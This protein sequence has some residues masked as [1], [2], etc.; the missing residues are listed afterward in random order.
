[1]KKLKIRT[2]IMLWFTLL[3]AILLGAL[4]PTVYTSVATSLRQT[5]QANLQMTISQVFSSVESK[6]G[7]L[8]LDLEELDI[9]DGI[10]LNILSADGS[11]L[12]GSQSTAWLNDEKLESGENYLFVNGKQWAVQ[13]QHY[14]IDD[15]K[16]TVIAAS[17]MDYVKESLNDLILL[18]LVLVPVYLLFSA[19]GAFFLA[20][21][22][23]HPIHQITQ[24]AQEISNGNME[25]RIRNIDT[26]DEVGELADTFNG[27]LDTLEVSFQRERQFTSDAS[28]ELRTPI[29]VISACTEDALSNNATD[30]R[31]SL[32]TIKSETERMTKIIS[33]LLMLSRGYEGRYHFEPD[34][35]CL[36]DMVDSVSEELKDAAENMHIAIHN[37]IPESLEIVADQSLMTQLMINLIGNAIKYGHRTGNVWLNAR[38]EDGTIQIEISDDGIGI[39]EEDQVHI[40]DRFYRADKSRDRSG[41]GLGLAIV[42]WIVELHGGTIGVKSKLGH[43]T[44]FKIELHQSTML[45]R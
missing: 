41:S 35:L 14:E 30:C 25:Q 7:R 16:M 43:G 33:Q 18:L 6:N 11:V 20:K 15:A 19:V 3:S 10:A 36:F 26:R 21:R 42:K 40:F 1:M 37:D 29:T 23:M 44:I 8:V 34:R 5:L 22:A 17:S 13:M 27:M 2:K 45:T 24:T 9:Q 38:E 32:E 28:H 12:Y 4:I 39:S 31:E